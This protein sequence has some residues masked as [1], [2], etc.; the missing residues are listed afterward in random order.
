MRRPQYERSGLHRAMDQMAYWREVAL[1]SHGLEHIN[2]I[3]KFHYWR[4][5]VRAIRLA[6]LQQKFAA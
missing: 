3:A 1:L 4:R 2:A 5:N 6:S